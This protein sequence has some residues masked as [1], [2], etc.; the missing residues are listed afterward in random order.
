[1]RIVTVLAATALFG[2]TVVQAQQ[3]PPDPGSVPR[4]QTAPS[5]APG[6]TQ[7]QLGVQPSPDRR[8]GPEDDVNARVAA[9]L[10]Q[11]KE[12]LRLTPDQ[13]K[14]WPA[15]EAGLREFAKVREHS[16][17]QDQ[18]PTNPVQRLRHNAERLG[19]MSA[20]LTRLADVEEPL[21]KSLDDGQKER[22][23]RLARQVRREVVEARHHQTDAS[24]DDR[25]RYGRDDES[26]RHAGNERDDD[27]RSSDRRGMSRHHYMMHD[28]DD[29]WRGHHRRM[30]RDMDDDDRHMRRGRMDDRRSDWRHDDRDDRYDRRSDR[31]DDR[32]DRYDRRSDRRDDPDDRYD[33]R[34]SHDRMGDMRGHSWRHDCETHYDRR[35]DRDDDRDNDRDDHRDDHRDDDRD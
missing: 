27:D 20:A 13:E 14:N 10:A 21:Y 23:V 17:D 2:S 29:G 12:A 33:R 31:R 32:D 8:A 22:F 34:G 15:F 18:S 11:F 9:R 6:K 16:A 4:T 24:D 7:D 26:G 19:T 28:D 1:M 35:S 30:G 25:S 5:P 3:L